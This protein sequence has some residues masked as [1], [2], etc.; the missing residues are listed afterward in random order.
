MQSPQQ[1]NLVSADAIRG[2]I[3]SGEILTITEDGLYSRDDVSSWSPSAASA[4]LP[5]RDT[6]KKRAGGKSRRGTKHY[7]KRNDTRKR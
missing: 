5:V 7:K 1:R 6:G 2:R 3:A 4:A